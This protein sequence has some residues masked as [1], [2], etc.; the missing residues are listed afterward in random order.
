MYNYSVTYISTDKKR[1]KIQFEDKYEYELENRILKTILH[2]HTSAN[3][4][5]INQFLEKHHL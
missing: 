2:T 5:K 4:Y 3:L 1:Q